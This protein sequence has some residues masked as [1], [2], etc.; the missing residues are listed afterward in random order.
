MTYVA[1]DLNRDRLDALLPANGLRVAQPTMFIVE[2]LT[3]YLPEHTVRLM[4]SALA[5]IAAPG[6]RL[7]VNFTVQGGGSVSP[8]SQA[9]A[10]L[11]RLTWRFRGEPTHGWVRRDRLPELL[12]DTGWRTTTILPAPDLARRYLEARSL[13]V[14]GLNPGAICVAADRGTA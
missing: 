4:L 13:R 11:T 12:T 6:S 14:D 1:A 7:A 5:A 9:I 10:W 2:G 8:V 3:M